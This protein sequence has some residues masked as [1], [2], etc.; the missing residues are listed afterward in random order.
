[1]GFQCPYIQ[2][3]AVAELAANISA[4][5]NMDGEFEYFFKGWNIE[6]ILNFDETH[7]DRI[8]FLDCLK[9]KLKG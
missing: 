8:E 6:K 3:Y 1:M 9:S 2:K 5:F 4:Y 7:E